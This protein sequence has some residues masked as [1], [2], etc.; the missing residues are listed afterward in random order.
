M[1]LLLQ[2]VLAAVLGMFVLLIRKKIET[3]D[4]RN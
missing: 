4:H 3:K 2:G 1:T